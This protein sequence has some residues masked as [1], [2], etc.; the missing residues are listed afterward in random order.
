MPI[1][2]EASVQQSA[3]TARFV[4]SSGNHTKP[5][6]SPTGPMRTTPRSQK[7]AAAPYQKNNRI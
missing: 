6:T 1:S 4:Q 7:P 3:D 2:T 5:T